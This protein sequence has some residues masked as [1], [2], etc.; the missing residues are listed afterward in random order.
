[1]SKGIVPTCQASKTRLCRVLREGHGGMGPASRGAGWGSDPPDLIN[2]KCAVILAGGQS[3]RFGRDKTSLT[4]DGE[5]LLARLVTMLRAEGFEVT[6]L[7]PPKS[8]F[9][10]LNCRIVPD[11]TP[12]EG[13]LPA[14]ANALAQL[15]ADRLLAVA[16]DMPFLM[17]EMVQLLWQASPASALTYLEGEVLPAVYA[18][19][20]LPTLQTLV[21]TGERRLRQAHAALHA[22]AHVIPSGIWHAV[23]N[24]RQSVININTPKDMDKLYFI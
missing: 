5:L 15:P 1:M 2:N 10:A 3:R 18:K 24:H 6:L 21:A 13:P 7:G 23:D 4:L 12:H 19:S 14:I 17:P 8:H 16:A 20:A 22:S 11:A 9:S